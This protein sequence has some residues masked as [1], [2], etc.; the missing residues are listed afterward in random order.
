[1]IT[2]LIGGF[3]VVAGNSIRIYRKSVSVYDLE[4]EY[5][6]EEMPTSK[7]QLSPQ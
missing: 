4:G 3:L 5:S 2:S 6:L 7:I 1:M